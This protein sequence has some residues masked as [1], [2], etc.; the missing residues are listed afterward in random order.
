MDSTN[1]YQLQSPVNKRKIDDAETTFTNGIEATT[2]KAKMEKRMKEAEEGDV[3]N[4]AS[5]VP[6]TDARMD[7]AAAIYRMRLVGKSSA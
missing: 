2:T 4:N 3:H 5:K 1:W 6:P 7:H